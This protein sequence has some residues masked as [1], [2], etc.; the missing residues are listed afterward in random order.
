MILEKYK[1]ENEYKEIDINILTEDTIRLINTLLNNLDGP[2][3]LDEYYSYIDNLIDYFNHKKN[4]F[5][6]YDRN[7]IDKIYSYRRYMSRLNKKITVRHIKKEYINF[8]KYELI[9][10]D[11]FLLEWNFEKNKKSQDYYNIHKK[12][13]E[14][15]IKKITHNEISSFNKIDNFSNV[16]SYEKE[17][18]T[19]KKSL[20]NYFN[21]IKIPTDI[22]YLN[23][24]IETY[25]NSL[26]DLKGTDIHELDRNEKDETKLIMSALK[27]VELKTNY[28]KCVINIFFN[29]YLNKLKIYLPNLE[30]KEEMFYMNESVFMIFNNTD[31]LLLEAEEFRTFGYDKDKLK[32]VDNRHFRWLKDSM[33]GIRFYVDSIYHQAVKHLNKFYDYERLKELDNFNIYNNKYLSMKVEDIKNY[34]DFIDNEKN[35]F[36]MKLESPMNYLNHKENIHD[37]E[38]LIKRIDQRDSIYKSL[39]H[40]YDEIIK[41][42]DFLKNVNKE[43]E[44]SLLFDRYYKDL[45]IFMDE[46]METIRE[47]LLSYEIDLEQ[48]YIPSGAEDYGKFIY[49]LSQ[50][51]D[52]D[53]IL[54]L[55]N[56]YEQ[57][58]RVNG[59]DLFIIYSPITIPIN[60]ELFPNSMKLLAY[61]I[62]FRNKAIDIEII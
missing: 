9:I 14:K 57:L 4:M 6:K 30:E 33:D 12:V 59:Q 21:S 40:D 48:S 11:T 56:R 16:V 3:A 36:L 28:V 46:E 54:P 17:I 18:D 20:D 42:I 23:Q 43:D 15:I 8:P 44:Y 47:K 37:R 1:K 49:K 29:F 24:Y 51:D 60:K 50:R 22:R 32:M 26:I 2:A 34:R 31:R 19:D 52:Y 41:Y 25:I 5:L 58:Q 55:L 45:G 10:P 53:K 35:Y 39:T 62:Y 7:M 38:I 27:M 61:L 13:Y